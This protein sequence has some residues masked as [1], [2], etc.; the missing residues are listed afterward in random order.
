MGTVAK[1][2]VWSDAAPQDVDWAVGEIERLEQCWSRFRSN[3]ELVTLNRAAGSGAV[4]VSETL[5]V[6][7]RRARD[8]YAL[9]N[10][11]FDPTIYDALVALGYDRT[12]R[13]L[14]VTEPVTRT[15]ATRGFA[16][17]QL[18]DREGGG[19]IATMPRGVRID[20]GGIGKGLAVDLVVAGLAARGAT[21]VCVSLGGDMRVAGPG[22]DECGAWDIDIEDARSA[23]AR[24]RF[25][26]VDE[27]IAQSTTALR[28][29]HDTSGRVLHHIVDPA[30]GA[31]A[32]TSLDAVVVTAREA[33]VADVLA[34]AALIAGRDGALALL[35]ACA[36]DGWLFGRD[37]EVVATSAVT[38][39]EIAS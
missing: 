39:V 9:T 2:L 8:G 15:R 30:T 25:P 26:L 16:S 20:L 13:D 28:C 19:A 10:G 7:L 11:R 36:A 34:K 22:P 31:P 32:D 27:A 17:L 38:D 1:V 24:F 12:F 14:H 5:A 21:S 6:A 3:S 33:W 18:V 4:E 23:R 37:G 29:W 35:A